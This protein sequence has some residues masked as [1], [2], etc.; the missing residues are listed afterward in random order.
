[1][2]L[3]ESASVESLNVTIRADVD[4]TNE[5]VEFQTTATS[6]TSPDPDGWVAGTWETWAN[7][8]AV[9]VTPT[10]GATGAGI[11]LTEGDVVRLWCRIGTTVRRVIS[12]NVV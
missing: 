10:L 2:L 8:R 3:F 1:M 4:P 5:D 11:E 9:A 12:L 6:E 7:G